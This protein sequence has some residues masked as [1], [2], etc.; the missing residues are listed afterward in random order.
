M[1]YKKFKSRSVRSPK[2]NTCR[3]DLF[4]CRFAWSQSH[5]CMRM[6]V[7][8]PG[9]PVFSHKFQGKFNASVFSELAHHTE[10][11]MTIFT[12]WPLQGFRLFSGKSARRPRWLTSTKTKVLSR[13]F[14]A[15]CR[16]WLITAV[17][18]VF[19]ELE[20]SDKFSIE[21]AGVKIIFRDFHARMSIDEIS[22]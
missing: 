14:C 21:F 4:A 22:T 8:K 10:T 20:T 7:E 12:T 19:G 17:T 5:S 2:T 1:V 9:P 3:N 6:A 18:G 13:R 16:V 15:G 11:K